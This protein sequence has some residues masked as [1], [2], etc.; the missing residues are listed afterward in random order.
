MNN[1]EKSFEVKMFS[2][3]EKEAENIEQL[4]ERWDEALIKLY[5]YYEV[6]NNSNFKQNKLLRELEEKTLQ[7]VEKE[8]TP[9]VL[10]FA[11]PGGA[12]KGTVR[13]QVKNSIDIGE[14]INSTTRQR[15]D[16]EIDGI[17]YDFITT[18]NLASDIVL[19]EESLRQVEKILK[20][21]KTPDFLTKD[22]LNKIQNLFDEKFQKGEIEDG[23]DLFPNVNDDKN[24][25]L[26]LTLRPLR[27][28]YGLSVNGLEK[29][30]SEN[31]VSTFEE[32]APNMLR[33]GEGVK[34]KGINFY[35]IYVLPEQPIAETMARRALKRDGLE[36][37]TEKLL[38][39]IGG[40]QVIEF[41]KMVEMLLSG[42]YLTKPVFL[43][44]DEGFEKD[45]QFI[46]RT[47]QALVDSLE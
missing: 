37:P 19:T 2:R 9:I 18:E 42:T 23:I 33:I 45:G 6:E 13:E 14:V 34:E 25:F 16:Y 36:Q 32:S 47:G 8:R 7:T 44:N 43:L 27:G 17:H 10:G 40:R 46:T 39:T 12:G 22:H 29:A 5:G 1:A 11:G 30:T 26:N 20:L 15:R 4:Q 35:L 31:K 3:L 21:E 24:K 38:S 41:E 28:W